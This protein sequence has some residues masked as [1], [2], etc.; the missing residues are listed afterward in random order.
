MAPIIEIKNLSKRYNITGRKRGY[1]ALR[2]VITEKLRHP[3]TALLNLGRSML[4]KNGMEIFWALKDINLSVERGE[5]VGIIGANGA[6]KSTLLKIL[7]RITPP[8]EGEIRLNGKLASL[9]EV[10]TG[11]HP[12]LSGRENIY[13]N[14]AILGMTRKEIA[15][16]F[17]DIVSFSGIGDFI[18][19]PVKRY[20]S[21]MYVRLAFSIA[22]HIE[23]DILLVD[24]VLAV[25]DA[26][27]QKKCLGKM[28]EVTGKAGRTILFVS[29]NMAAVTKLCPTSVLLS[30]GRIVMTGKTEDVINYYLAEEY[31]KSSDSEKLLPFKNQD[32]VIEKFD[33]TQNGTRTETLDGDRPFEITIKFETLV[34]L[35]QFRL[36]IYV[37]N[38]LG[39]VLFRSTTSDWKPE[40]EKIKR[41][42]HS[43]T[44]V[45][46]GKL[47]MPGSYFLNIHAGRFSI[48]NYMAK[49]SL[50]RTIVVGASAYF[51]QAHPAERTEGE[52][53]LPS[54]WK[55]ESVHN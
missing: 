30:H 2:D 33:V 45:F 52:L 14:G 42:R 23:P 19:T 53:L 44:L 4:G 38:S 10:G 50:D 37:K 55:L 7:S 29:H 47:L 41:G 39:S 3:L 13:L 25:G 32:L 28:E 36:G 20:S 1:V 17:D 22:A 46:P 43:A 31:K 48:I 9:L 5:A 34:D 8:T 49:Q 54:E 24:E 6:G 11:F 18:D 35:T 15:D 16:K 27:F 26:E 40:L 12:E 51:N 21:G